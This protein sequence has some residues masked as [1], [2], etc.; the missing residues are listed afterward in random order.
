MG[1]TI[2]EIDKMTCFKRL[3]IDSL[4]QRVRLWISLFV[5]ALRSGNFTRCHRYELILDELS[6]ELASRTQ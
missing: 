2:P 6:S 1:D 5:N 4:E 3:N